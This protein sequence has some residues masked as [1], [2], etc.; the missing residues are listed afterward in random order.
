MSPE[1][2]ELLIRSLKL[3]EENNRILLKLEHTIR[4]QA[5]WGLVKILIIIVPLVV[6]YIFLQPYIGSIT[7]NASQMR[8]LLNSI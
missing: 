7:N 1:E 8:E 5:I 3:S 2:K 6:G 4:L